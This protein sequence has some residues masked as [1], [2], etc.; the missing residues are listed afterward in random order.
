[1]LSEIPDFPT[2]RPVTAIYSK[3]DGVVAW[4]ACVDPDPNTR[5]VEVTSS[6]FGLGLGLDPDVLRAVAQ[7]LAATAP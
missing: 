1:M 7:T 3:N 6:H 5:N 4:R 2:P